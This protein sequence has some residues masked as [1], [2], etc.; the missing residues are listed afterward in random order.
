MVLFERIPLITDAV[1]IGTTTPLAKLHVSSTS[2]T[3][4]LVQ[5]ASRSTVDLQVQLDNLMFPPNLNN[6]STTITNSKYANGTYTV[7][8]SDENTSQGRFAYN[9]FDSSP[10]SFWETNANFGGGG[11]TWQGSST[12]VPGFTTYTGPSLRITFPISI[13][14]QS[15]SFTVSGAGYRIISYYLFASTN[16]TSWTLLHLT[17]NGNNISNTITETLTPTATTYNTFMFI[18]TRI[19]NSGTVRITDFRIYGRA[20]YLQ[21]NTITTYSS[22][23]VFSKNDVSVRTG[24]IEFNDA[25]DININTYDNVGI[26][27]TN[28]VYKLD[29]NGNI[30]GSSRLILGNGADAAVYSVNV[31]DSSLTA[32]NSRFLTLGKAQSAN[33]QLEIQYRHVDDGSSSNYGSLGLYG[34]ATL[35]WTGTGNVGV[36]ITNP[37]CKLDVNGVIQSSNIILTNNANLRVNQANYNIPIITSY[38][39]SSAEA[40]Q[41]FS[42]DRR[43]FGG[44]NFNIGFN[45]N[46]IGGTSGHLLLQ[47]DSIGNVG[48]GITTNPSYKLDVS[49]QIRSLFNTGHGGLTLQGSGADVSISLNNSSAGGRNWYIGAGGASSGSPSN[50]FIY[51]NTSFQQR[52]AINPNGNVGI[53]GVVSPQNRLDINGSCAIGSY[54]GVN[55]APANSLIVSGNVGIGTRNSVNNLDVR[56]SCAIGTYAGVNSTSANN[57]IVSGSV[58]IGTASPHTSQKLNIYSGSASIMNSSGSLPVTSGLIG[59]YTGDSWSGVRNTGWYD[60]SGN[61]TTATTNEFWGPLIRSTI[62]D[63]NI[64]FISGGTGETVFF[65]QTLTFSSYTVFH[66]A[67]YSS[68]TNQTRII[69]TNGSPINWLSGFDGGNAGVAY[70]GAWIT[71]T[72]NVYGQNWVISTDQSGVYRTFGIDRT[73]GTAPTITGSTTFSFGINYKPSG[74]NWNCGWNVAEVIIYNRKL[75]S[76]E[77]LLMEGYLMD[78]YKAVVSPSASLYLRSSTNG[79][80]IMSFGD[81]VIP[82]IGNIGIGITNPSTRL[83]VSGTCKINNSGSTGA[84]HLDN[85]RA[86]GT[87]FPANI[88]LRMGY[89]GSYLYHD[90]ETRHDQWGLN[91]GNNGIDV[92]VYNSNATFNGRKQVMSIT[93]SGVGIG[94]TI[95]TSS[96]HVSG[97]ITGTTKNFDIVHPLPSKNNHHLVHASIEGPRYDLMYRGSKT[98]IDGVA[99]VNIDTESVHEPDCAMSEGTFEAL[100]RNPMYYLQ[101]TTSFD[102]VIGSISGNKLTIQSENQNSTD[103]IY[104]MV[105]AERKDPYILECGNTNSN[106]YLKPEYVSS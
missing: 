35:Y 68:A 37:T 42:I 5:G 33:N 106:G 92:F 102:R 100:S 56:G 94:V 90:I 86:D 96:L 61:N 14:P 4:I 79:A 62:P 80:S 24:T 49:G 2:G 15:F 19:N 64:S 34:S 59:W 17:I 70:Q 43:N 16:D 3:S 57:L 32:N 7:V 27:T 103:T 52:F 84:L 23:I 60:L 75:S 53:G 104:W 13:T 91:S 36:G 39:G 78:K 82:T 28:P 98:L 46:A 63:T 6:Y 44:Q 88:Q 95:P 26:G 54:A 72:T 65:P 93:G 97:T 9:A 89:P 47:P 21:N 50:L 55:S 66:V 38:D 1:G 8:A 58:G 22:N 41:L 45:V 11:S 30:R 25:G 12:T 73:N 77:I 101:N 29:V 87:T 71:P 99:Q 76:S 105:I 83:V 31:T 67:R 18:P 40:A 74:G 81:I 20:P 51:D 10:S 85:G 48:I 69:T